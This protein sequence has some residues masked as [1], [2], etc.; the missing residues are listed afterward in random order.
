V[1]LIVATVDVATVVVVTV[2]VADVAPAATVT[3][4]GTVAEPLSLDRVTTAA[5]AGA[6]LARVTVPVEE[7]PP[8]TDVGFTETDNS[9]GGLMVSAAD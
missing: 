2:K 3:L 1:P 4:A 5:P 8:V 6:G 9:T 7:P